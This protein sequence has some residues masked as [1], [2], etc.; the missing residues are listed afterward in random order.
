MLTGCSSTAPRDSPLREKQQYRKASRPQAKQARKKRAVLSLDLKTRVTALLARPQHDG[1]PR[2]WRR[3]SSGGGRSRTRIEIGTTKDRL[4]SGTGRHRGPWW[5]NRRAV[6]QA[7][8][9]RR[10]SSGEG[11]PHSRSSGWRRSQET[12]PSCRRRN[13]PQCVQ[14][15]HG[16]GMP[17]RGLLDRLCEGPPQS[18]LVPKLLSPPV[19]TM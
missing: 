17:N 10:A 5:T 1:Q 6:G 9:T 19:P 2:Y 7:G 13:N 3:R 16:P 15:P 8:L 14:H 4:A 11:S 18:L 12:C